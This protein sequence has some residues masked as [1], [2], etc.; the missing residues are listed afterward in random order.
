MILL[1]TQGFL[2]HQGHRTKSFCALP[3]AATKFNEY[4]SVM[5]ARTRRQ[6]GSYSPSS[7]FIR[8]VSTS[9]GSRTRYSRSVSG[10]GFHGGAPLGTLDYLR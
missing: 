9:P 4:F 8:K 6:A 1:A 2:L 10:C 7:Y 5:Q 3:W